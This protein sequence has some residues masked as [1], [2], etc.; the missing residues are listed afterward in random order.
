M[1]ASTLPIPGQILMERRLDPLE[2]AL[3]T[4]KHSCAIPQ[5]HV[6]SQDNLLDLVGRPMGCPEEG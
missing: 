6:H 3:R 1:G 5:P 2:M 4:G